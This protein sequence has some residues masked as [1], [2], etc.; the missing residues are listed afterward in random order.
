MKAHIE[1]PSLSESNQEERLG[2]Q[3]RAIRLLEGAANRLERKYRLG[4]VRNFSYP[5]R[6]LA[7]RGRD[8]VVKIPDFMSHMGK[9]LR[10]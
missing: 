9:Y 8:S 4:K 6:L 7:F 3:K 10:L 1:S 5:V 2:G